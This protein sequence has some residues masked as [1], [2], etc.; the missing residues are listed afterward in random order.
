MNL[1][2]FAG[3][4]TTRAIDTGRRD[5]DVSNEIL[6]L[7][8]DATPFAIILM[9]AKKQMTHSNYF[10]WYDS[11]LGEWWGQVDSADE[12][13]ASTTT[14]P[15]K[16]PTVFQSEGHR[17]GSFYWRS[18]ICNRSCNYCRKRSN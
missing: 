8:P 7:N 18:F 14:I 13:A 12:I 2:L 6:R 9:K 5:L 17:K 16:D 1:Q 15:V 10:Y 11:K 4:V 3:P